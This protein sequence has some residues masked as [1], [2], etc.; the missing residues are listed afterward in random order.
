[1]LAT[2]RRVI[3][4]CLERNVRRRIAPGDREVTLE[5]NN[6][7]C[8]VERR[9]A[10]V[11]Q[12]AIEAAVRARPSLSGEQR[13]MVRQLTPSRDAVMAVRGHAG[14]GK[15]TALDACRE[16]GRG[17]GAPSSAAR[18]PAAP[19]RSCRPARASSRRPLSASS[20]IS[21]TTATQILPWGNAVLVVDEAGMVGTRL[22]DRVL[23][24]AGKSD[25]TVVL[26]G[27]DS[28]APRDRRRR[29]LPQP[30]RAPRRCGT[31]GQPAPTGRVGA[32]GADLLREGRSDEALAAYVEHGRVVLG[33]SAACVRARLVADWWVAEQSGGGR[34]HH[35]GAAPRRRQR[36]Q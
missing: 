2:E 1:M 23:T 16:I 10:P 5:L 20:S 4:G 11:S 3:D 13:A 29:R 33:P 17:V 6:G 30:V 24:A 19:R 32:P 31:G 36:A 34:Q 26:V 14:T 21:S 9:P 22:L 18:C 35:G 8:V 25:A 27:D 7:L 28:S 15:T 12:A